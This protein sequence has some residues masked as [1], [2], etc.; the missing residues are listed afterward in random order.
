MDSFCKSS[1]SGQKVT[2]RYANL[3]K[4]SCNMC[5]H[6]CQNWYLMRKHVRT[7]G[8]GTITSIKSFI[9]SVTLHKCHF[10]KEYIFCD[11]GIINDH[12]KSHKLS[13]ETYLNMAKLPDSQK[14]QKQYQSLLRAAIK[15][16]PV[17]KQKY[18]T[19]GTK[20]V[21]KA[22]SIPNDQVT[23]NVGNLTF[24]EC[25]NCG[26]TDMSYNALVKHSKNKH[27]LKSLNQLDWAAEVRYH[28]CHICDRIVLCDNAILSSHLK[29][30]HKTKLDRYMKDFVLKRGG[31]VFP[32][33]RDYQRDQ[34]VFKSF[35]KDDIDSQDTANK[36]DKKNDD[37]IDA[38]MISSESDDSDED[39]L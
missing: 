24:F 9:T 30:C 1:T 5:G 38:S 15:N 36:S 37:L 12:V 7:K 31:K 8:H 14:I 2:D 25:C 35:S 27:G 16:I 23:E 11:K 20:R 10:C 6:Y 22:K 19:G 33:F 26:K 18:S 28:K 29:R 39:M 17:I 34:D 4:F 13:V 3:C 21:L 32:T